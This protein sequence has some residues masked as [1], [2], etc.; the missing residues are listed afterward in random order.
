MKTSSPKRKNTLAERRLRNFYSFFDRHSV[1][2]ILKKLKEET[3]LKAV[4]TRCNKRHS[5]SFDKVIITLALSNSQKTLS[6]KPLE[7]TL[8]CHTYQEQTIHFM[9]PSTTHVQS[10]QILTPHKRLALLEEMT[11]TVVE[12]VIRYLIHEAL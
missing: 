11:K 4:I 6:T 3:G 9:Q 5:A 1:N 7:V 2:E 12:Q 8:V 10:F